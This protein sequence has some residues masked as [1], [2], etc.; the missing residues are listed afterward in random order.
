[1]L[2][3]SLCSALLEDQAWQQDV[4]PGVHTCTLAPVGQHILSCPMPEMLR[5]ELLFCQSGTVTLE[6]PTAPLT[7]TTGQILLLSSPAAFCSAV[8]SENFRGILV[9][10]DPPRARD[11]L[12]LLCTLLGGVSLETLQVRRIMAAYGGC[13]ILGCSTWSQSVF[14]TLEQLPPG[15]QSRYCVLKAAE[16]LYLL[17]CRTLLP[18]PPLKSTYQDP[19]LVSQV[20]QIHDY[21]L[22]HLGDALTIQS[23]AVQFRVSATAFKRCFRQLYGTPVH[24]YLQQRRM[25]RASELIRSSTLP[26]ARVAEMVSYNSAS[27]FSAAFRR[28]FQLSPTQYRRQVWEKNV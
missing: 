27:Q 25:E 11:S 20:H 9:S 2:A 17:S 10:V 26:V 19:Y 8:L 18:E 1:M 24:R 16:L 7:L 6:R 4:M 28:Q 23:L 22:A 3:E 14:S 21:M 15:E 5:H 12:V 13:A